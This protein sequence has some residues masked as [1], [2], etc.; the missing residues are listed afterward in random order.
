MRENRVIK[1]TT[2]NNKNIKDN[3][4]ASKNKKILTLRLDDNAEIPLIITY[5]KDSECFN[6]D[7][8]DVNKIRVSNKKL[9]SKEHNSYKY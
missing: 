5:M 6:I 7:D 8:I 1:D 3:K 2:K 4:K 9:Y